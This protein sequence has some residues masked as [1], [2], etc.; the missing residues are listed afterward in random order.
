MSEPKQSSS[1]NN[2]WLIATC[3]DCSKKI[4]AKREILQTASSITCPYC[5]SSFKIGNNSKSHSKENPY[6]KAEKLTDPPE[7]GIRK[8][9]S[10]KKRKIIG[11]DLE[12]VDQSD[13]QNE[14]IIVRDS[15]GNKVRK[16]RRRSKK[17][18]THSKAY[19]TLTRSSLA[20][21]TGSGVIL[22]G[23]I[24]YKGFNTIDRDLSVS[25]NSI[26]PIFEEVIKD[27]SISLTNEERNTCIN[28][29]KSFLDN[30]GDIKIED[31]ILHPEITMPRINEGIYGPGGESYEG[32]IDSTKFKING[33]FIILLRLKISNEFR[34]SRTFAFEQTPKSIKMNW[35]VSFGHQIM[36]VSEFITTK[37][38]ADQ[39]FKV[40]L[41]LGDYYSHLYTN[42]SIWQCLEITYP[43]DELSRT[44]AYIKRDSS[45]GAE[46]INQLKPTE[47]ILRSTK[48]KPQDL[49]VIAKLQFNDNSDQNNQVELKEI[50]QYDWF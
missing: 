38:N 28:I 25:N 21:L 43:N 46:I 27:I 44:F 45:L 13:D 5:Q 31:L 36:T 9:K 37:P 34:R 40:T 32:I 12:E 29:V 26:E 22:L 3:P 8:R 4:K 11:W 30:S 17:G 20:I 24:V 16:I 33:K 15:S 1:S 14:V 2:D 41:R 50:L 18:N 42:D 19:K 7:K 23:A 48:S 6:A 35:E 39:T 47:S 10:S 49:R